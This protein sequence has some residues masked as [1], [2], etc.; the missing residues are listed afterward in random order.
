MIRIFKLFL[1]V[2]LFSAVAGGLLSLLEAVTRE[3]IETQQL[4]YLK[5]PAVLEIMEGCSND[6]LKDRFKISLKEK[7]QEMQFFVG[8]FDGKPKAIAF[9]VYGKGF[10]GKMGVIVGIDVET[11]KLLGIAVTTHSETPGLG[12]LAKTD[13]SFKGQFKGAGLDK[14][15]KVKA[16]GGDVDAL[17][18]ATITSRGV[19]AAVE[20]AISIYKSLKGDI[21][22]NLQGV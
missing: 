7:E 14:G 20:E 17:S 10:G 9:E 18:G 8:K 12:A 21:L 13:R 6:P 16:D 15:F 1:T 11:D 4:Q 5:G 3:R 2:F 22:K 19:C